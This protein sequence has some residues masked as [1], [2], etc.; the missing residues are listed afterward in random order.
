VEIFN[1]RQ[2]SELEVKKRYQIQISNS[3]AALDNLNG[4][5]K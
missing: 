3:Y 1:L 4:G 5:H 2:I